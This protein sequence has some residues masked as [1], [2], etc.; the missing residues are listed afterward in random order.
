M[1]LLDLNELALKAKE[2]CG[3]YDQRE[4]VFSDTFKTKFMELLP[5]YDIKFHKYTSVVKTKANNLLIIVP[6]QWFVIG[7]FFSDYI[8]ALRKYKESVEALKI[9]DAQIKT[10]RDAK[11][12]DEKTEAEITS[13][14]TEPEDSANFIKFLTDYSWWFG[15]K[16]IDRS[17]YFVS[18]VLNLAGVVNVTQTYI[19]DLAWILSLHKDLI[20]IFEQDY[21]SSEKIKIS[22]SLQKIYY[23]APGTGKSH[24]IETI[25]GEIPED[26]KERITFHPEYDYSCFVG[27]Y[28]PESDATGNIQ[29]KFVPQVFTKIYV[30]AWKNPLKD[31]YLAIEE[32]NRGNCAEIFGDLFQL[33]DRNSKYSISPSKELKDHLEE[34]LTTP[35]EKQGIK[36]GKMK[37]PPNLNILASMNTSDKSLFPMDSAFKR[38]W[39]WEYIPICYDETPQN[40]SFHYQVNIDE[41]TSFKWIDFI[42]NINAIIK[43]NQN[44]GMDKCIGNYF[45]K[46]D[47]KEISLNEFV[48]KAIFYLWNDVFK[49][50]DSSESIFEKGIS[51]EDF[52]PISTNG[53]DLLEKILIKNNIEILSKDI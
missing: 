33:L 51:Y 47:S 4:F 28:K 2:K 35:A 38:R 17:D 49:D 39:D 21:I 10:F 36:D 13:Y 22:K 50:E 32:I 43:T 53:K 23:G 6:N 27:G 3:L 19:A 15:S 34:K 12:I 40:E 18:P 29:Y 37:L 20:E 30:D 8:E 41:T 45:I 25:L 44:L 46:S 14:L 9:T 5:D 11:S 52:F 31:Y 7:S 24:T 1:R 42:K 16:T 48:N 26:Q